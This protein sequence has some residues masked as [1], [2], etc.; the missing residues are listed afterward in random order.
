MNGASCGVGRN[1][2]TKGAGQGGR[3]W[4]KKDEQGEKEARCGREKGEVQLGLQRVQRAPETRLDRDTC[5]FSLLAT[6][7]SLLVPSIRRLP[8]QG[9]VSQPH[10]M[11]ARG[12]APQTQLSL[13]TV[14]GILVEGSS[15][16]S[17]GC[18]AFEILRLRFPSNRRLGSDRPRAASNRFEHATKGSSRSG[19][20]NLKHPKRIGSLSLGNF[21]SGR[22][23]G[24]FWERFF[25]YRPSSL[26][27]SDV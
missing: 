10:F 1:A 12:I 16:S 5:A 13:V 7:C 21:R 14:E 11:L 25:C 27:D 4:K 23:N 6:R 3:R 22:S 9:I 2:R 18:H 17:Y 20:S 24:C 26:F 8:F 19:R 15:R